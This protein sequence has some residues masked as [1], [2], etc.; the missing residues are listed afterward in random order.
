MI[1]HPAQPGSWDCRACGEPWPCP[2]AK[3]QML[4][5]MPSLQLATYAWSCF[6]HA[7]GD[8]IAMTVPQMYERF[9]GW[10]RPRSAPE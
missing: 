2:S 7:A 5:E 6:D 8:L 10:T 9:I 3:E 4:G 1:E